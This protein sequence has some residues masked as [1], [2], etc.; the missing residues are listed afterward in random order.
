VGKHCSTCLCGPPEL[1]Y[2]PVGDPDSRDPFEWAQARAP[3]GWHVEG[4]VI[5]RRWM[6]T[7]KERE[8]L[9]ADSYRALVDVM[10]QAGPR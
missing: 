5:G 7:T 4:Q 6:A 10:T 1:S 3:E 8:R 2:G 9:T